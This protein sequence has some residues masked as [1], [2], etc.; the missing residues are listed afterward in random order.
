MREK[1]QLRYTNNFGYE[2]W[3]YLT[4]YGIDRN[5]NGSCENDGTHINLQDNQRHFKKYGY[6]HPKRYPVPA[7]GYNRVVADWDN[8]RED[9]KEYTKIY[10]EDDYLCLPLIPTLDIALESRI[11]KFRRGLNHYHFIYIQALLLYCQK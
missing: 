3:N 11:Q 8:R 1:Y 9:Y 7:H 5:I 2:E 6:Y 4:E 10:V